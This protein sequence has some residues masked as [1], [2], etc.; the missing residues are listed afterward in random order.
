M[1]TE[2]PNEILD[3]VLQGLDARDE[4]SLMYTSKAVRSRLL[5]RMWYR[6]HVNSCSDGVVTSST[7]QG[8]SNS[9][10]D[11]R[12]HIDLANVMNILNNDDAMVLFQCVRCLVLD[13]PF[14]VPDVIAAGTSKQLTA[15]SSPEQVMHVFLCEALPAYF[16]NVDFIHVNL[17]L[18]VASSPVKYSQA[19]PNPAIEVME[20]SFANAQTTVNVRLDGSWNPTN[21]AIPIMPMAF[22]NLRV[23]KITCEGLD[24]VRGICGPYLSPTVEKFDLVDYR[25]LDA[26]SLQRFFSKCD[27][28]QSISIKWGGINNPE[29]IDWVPKSVKKLQLCNYH[30]NQNNVSIRPIQAAN[31]TCFKSYTRM[32]QV[33]K[34][35]RF[36]KLERLLV[37]GPVDDEGPLVSSISTAFE[38]S[39]YIHQLKCRRLRPNFVAKVLQDCISADRNTVRSLVVQPGASG[40]TVE[41]LW[42]LATVCS[43]IENIV[44]GVGNLSADELIACIQ[45]FILLC[46]N[47]K[48]LFIEH[49]FLYN[50]QQYSWLSPVT[51]EH[52]Y[53]DYSQIKVDKRWTFAIDLDQFKQHYLANVH[54][55]DEIANQLETLYTR[56]FVPEPVLIY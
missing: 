22:D 14:F 21:S 19:I 8:I 25:E 34:S 12:T 1:L 44:L 28:L 2:L 16:H 10:V 54:E 36:P 52:V 43:E 29:G 31:V 27:R 6:V 56:L 24:E 5:A 41:E 4:T 35:F 50:T 26:L 47:L 46:P 48:T 49:A 42:D 9:R 11:G 32:G 17:N 38:T 30:D 3:L 33:F 20:R 45:R 18:G 53:D 15:D 39:P 51:T 55:E 7:K 23:L 13:L 37:Q 40:C